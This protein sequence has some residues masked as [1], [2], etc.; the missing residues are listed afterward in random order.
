MM[1]AVYILLCRDGTYYTG[2]T[3]DLLKRLAAHKAGIA[4]KYTRSRGAVRF[5]YVERKKT[6]GGALRR[7]AAIKKLSRATK[8]SL[9]RA[10]GVGKRAKMR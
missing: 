9:I 4:S 8:E 10:G 2:I 5:A 7:E 1:Y 6:R 3:N